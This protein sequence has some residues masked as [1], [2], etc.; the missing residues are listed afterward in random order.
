MMVEGGGK[1]AKSPLAHA[2]AESM[3]R[4]I[5]SGHLEVGKPLPAERELAERFGVSRSLI[6]Q[7]VADLADRGV[8]RSQPHCRPVVVGIDTPKETS[9]TKKDHVSVWL[10]PYVDDYAASAIF[11]GI[12]RAMIGAPLRLVVASAAHGTWDEVL[13]SEDAFLREIGEDDSCAGALMWLLAGERSLPALARAREHKVPIVFV[14]RKPPKGFEADVVGTENVSAARRAVAHLIELGHRRIACIRNLDEVSTV[15]DRVRGYRSALEEGGIAVDESLIARLAPRGS[16]AEDAAVERVV[17]E[18]MALPEPP[19]A[20]F[21]INDST[22]LHAIEAL[23]RSGWTVPDQVSVL[24]FDGLLRWIPGG[25][26]LTTADQAFQRI[27]ELAA[28]TLLERIRE[29]EPT[30]YRHVLLDAPLRVQGSTA[31]PQ[32]DT[33]RGREA[34][35]SMEFV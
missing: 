12:Q 35:P 4:E 14:D 32:P 8:V 30:T 29:G 31:P 20:I 6:R 13:E 25:G 10:W 9:G 33:D 18:L 26:R 27:G 16:E 34:D 2:V 28:E 5:A 1:M 7:A 24:G 15:Q 23:E 22:A 21:A 17:N 19:T 11:R 3:A